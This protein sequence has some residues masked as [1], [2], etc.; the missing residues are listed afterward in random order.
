VRAR[1]F[2]KKVSNETAVNGKPGP[3][4]DRHMA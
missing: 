2:R 1:R 4:Q 3:P